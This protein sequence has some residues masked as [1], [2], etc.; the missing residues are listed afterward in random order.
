MPA[1]VALMEIGKSEVVL[2][3]RQNGFTYLALL[4]FIA[5]MGVVLS[6]LGI[7]W[8]QEGQRE[9]EQELLFV[10]NQFRQAIMLYY[11]RTPGNVQRYPAKLDDLLADT[12]YN[13]AQHYL[14]KIYRDPMTDSQQWGILIA[15]EGGIMGIYSLSKKQPLKNSGFEYSNREFNG[16]LHYSD[17][18]FGYS[19][20]NPKK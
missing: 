8:Q 14:R 7:N 20:S 4:F 10:G 9:R 11:E 13:P 15:P 1:M 5:I 18:V 12:R 3:K 2:F 19:P 6:T 17:W 16:A